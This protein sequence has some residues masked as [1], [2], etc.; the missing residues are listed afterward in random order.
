[1]AIKQ[2]TLLE[3]ILQTAADRGGVSDIHLIPGEPVC[4]RVR[5][6]IERTD[7]DPLTA[8]EIHD[9]VLA[10]VGQQQLD[11]VGRE[12][13]ET[14]TS[15]SLSGVIDGRL[16]V[17]RAT[18]D[19]TAVI[20]VIPGTVIDVKSAMIPE[21][22]VQA[23]ESAHGLVVVAGPTGSGKTTSA[24]SL[25]DHVN[26][27]KPV[28]I[29]TVEDPICACLTP[30][31]AL[32]QQRE[33]GVDVPDIVAGIRAALRQDLDVLYLS[34][35]TNAEE[36]QAAVTAADWGHM[37]LCVMHARSPEEVVDRL[38]DVH[39]EETRRAFQTTLAR[40]L[41]AVSVQCLLRSSTGK[42]RVA[43]YGVLIPDQ[44][45]LRGIAVR[46]EARQGVEGLPDG[47]QLITDDI[48]RL[49]DTGIAAADAAETA[50]AS[51]V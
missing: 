27:T 10:A 39:P 14:T 13:G 3:D 35:L 18:G 51:F 36:V 17:A 42:G 48:R 12:V 24:L 46:G 37:V 47:S 32:V 20:R 38:V 9:I 22:M 15:C 26:A 21:S 41:R 8:P 45:M 16:T 7:G 50:L 33:V 49:C 34:D 28:V 1:M 4:F 5:G 19:C 31:Q 29:C 43:A 2:T 11:R 44:E 6:A 30:K 25:L 40:V 23:V